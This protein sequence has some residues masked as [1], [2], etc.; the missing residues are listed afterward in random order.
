MFEV[1]QTAAD[2]AKC[3]NLRH[4]AMILFVFCRKGSSFNPKRFWKRDEKSVPGV[5]KWDPFW[6]SQTI[7]I[8]NFEGFPENNNALFGLV[9]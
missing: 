2:F 3:A 9:I 6:G 8:H 4:L 5:I 1:I 7:Q